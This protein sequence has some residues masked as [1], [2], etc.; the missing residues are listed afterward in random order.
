MYGRGR[1]QVEYLADFATTTLGLL[2]VCDWLDANR[3]SRVAMGGHRYVRRPV[4][5]VLDDRFDCLLEAGQLRSS[6]V[7]PRPG[8]SRKDLQHGHHHERGS[9]LG[10]SLPNPVRLNRDERGLKGG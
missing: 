9:Q 8:A 10:R 6:L 5:A 1:R 2:S 4:C 7:P 3:M